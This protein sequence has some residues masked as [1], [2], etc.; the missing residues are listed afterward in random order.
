MASDLIVLVAG[1]SGVLGSHVA[2]QFLE[3]RYRV[4]GMAREISKADAMKK[5]FDSKYGEGRVEVVTV[6]NIT[7][8]GAFDEAVKDM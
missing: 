1:I 5:V 7:I 2:D 6:P 8:D 4:R 3:A